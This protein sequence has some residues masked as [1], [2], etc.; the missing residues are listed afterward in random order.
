[1]KTEYWTHLRQ[2][3]TISA[4]AATFW[5]KGASVVFEALHL[6]QIKSAEAFL[7][8]E[9]IYCKRCNVTA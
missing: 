6:F 3:I 7:L 8:F 2:V 5:W 1:M 4:N 9:S